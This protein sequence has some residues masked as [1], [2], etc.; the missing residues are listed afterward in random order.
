MKSNLAM[1]NTATVDSPSI[2]ALV[3]DQACLCIAE[4][5]PI[6]TVLAM[7]SHMGTRTA[8]VLGQG[9]VFKGLVHRSSLLANLPGHAD[10][11]DS[12]ASLP[13]PRL[14]AG[15]IMITGQPVLVSELDADYALRLMTN[16]GYKIMPVLEDGGRFAGLADSAHLAARIGSGALPYIT[17]R[18]NGFSVV[19][20][21]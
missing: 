11:H 14:T 5:C 16:Y 13:S 2:G 9:G 17:R 10:I 7:M 18:A 4:D 12:V 1:K 6:D 19:R 20:G 8:A 3:S 21:R 15:D